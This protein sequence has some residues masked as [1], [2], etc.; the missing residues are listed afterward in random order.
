M[1]Y[2]EEKRSPG[3]ALKPYLKMMFPDFLFINTGPPTLPPFTNIVPR[4]L[5][6]SRL[7]ETKG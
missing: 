1:A 7:D 2:G 3:D 5:G 4:K 6:R